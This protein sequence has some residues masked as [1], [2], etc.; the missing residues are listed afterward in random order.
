VIL[1]ELLTRRLPF[2]GSD[3]D[4]LTAIVNEPPPSPRELAPRAGI[5]E[6][7]EAVVMRALVKEPRM[8]FES[9]IDFSAALADVLVGEVGVER[10]IM[11]PCLPS[12]AGCAEA[13][14]SPAGSLCG[15][16]QSSQRE[17]TGL[18]G[19]D[20]LL[21]TDHTGTLAGY[22]SRREPGRRGAGRERVLSAMLR[23]AGP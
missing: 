18:F 2:V 4:V 23:E 22:G 8:R 7:L 1:F 21:R 6:A 19:L 9:A 14:A 12:H 5:P 20:L 10:A 16:C 15:L 3:Y 17:R 13:E 11:Q